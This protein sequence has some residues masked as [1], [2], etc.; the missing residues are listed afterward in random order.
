M[1]IRIL[2]YFITVAR[3]GSV[4]GAAKLLHVTQPT[5]SR[6]LQSLEEELGQKLLLRKYHRIELTEN[7]MLLR[8]RAEEILDL[9]GKTEKDLQ[10]AGNAAAGEVFFGAGETGKM[11]TVARIM[12]HIREE[13][14][15]IRFRIHSGTA[16]D[17][18][19][20]LDR[21]TLDFGLL[22]NPGRAALEKYEHLDLPD[23]ESWGLLMRRD[24]PLAARRGVTPGDLAGVPLLLPARH[25]VHGAGSL[26]G[27]PE[28]CGE[29]FHALSVAGHYN[30]VYNAALL[31]EEG[32]GC[33]VSIDLVTRRGLRFRPLKP[34][35]RTKVCIA[36]KKGH[37][38]S[39]AAALFLSH[40]QRK[41]SA[42]EEEGE[43]DLS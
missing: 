13:Y 11:K 14:P 41:L 16:D 43:K 37:L 18:M 22:I 32:V 34:V 6:Q 7:G 23:G 33:A 3:T 26:S 2:R 19:E 9:V 35:I 4:T 24:C 10:K 38:F 27:F 42:G 1:E 36:W 31:V 8:D 29:S 12:G 28:W 25:V 39:P 20:R 5:L 30:L 21:E 17:L 15:G 40:L